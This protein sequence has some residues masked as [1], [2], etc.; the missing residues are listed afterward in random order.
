METFTYPIEPVNNPLFEKERQAAVQGINPNELDKPLVDIIGRFNKLKYVYTLQ[1]CYGHFLYGSQSHEHNL[2]PLPEY[3]PGMITYR[4]AYLAFCIRVD[5]EGLR[6]CEALM[7]LQDIDKHF[8]Q[9]GS[10]DWF[11]ER[12]INSYVLQVEPERYKYQD[13]AEVDWSEARHIQKIRTLFFN[14]LKTLILK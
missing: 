7:K 2:L 1:C 5:T 13:I 10:A 8:I 6:L 11:W 9:F 14:E 3:D 12:C 4:I